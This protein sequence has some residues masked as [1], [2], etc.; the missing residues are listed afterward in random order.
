[1]LYSWRPVLKYRILKAVPKSV[2]V[3]TTV[4]GLADI[5]FAVIVQSSSIDIT[6]KTLPDCPVR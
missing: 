4:S 1:M 5:A 2:L 6:Q 3:V